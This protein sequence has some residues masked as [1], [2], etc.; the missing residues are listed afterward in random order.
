M[1]TVV[2]S[3]GII[4][5]DSQTSAGERI[6]SLKTDKKQSFE[7]YHFFSAGR[8]VDI[9][10]L[11]AAVLSGAVEVPN[12]KDGTLQA[13]A[14]LV[15]PERD[16]YLCGYVDEELVLQPIEPGDIEAIGSGADYAIGAM[17]AGCDA[18][19]AVKIAAG[20]D[21]YTGGRIRKFIV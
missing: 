16:V 4:A 14:L 13:V 21:V 18:V 10:K 15:T 8:K 17:D 6:V 20:R 3:N 19:Q 2:Y 1:T 11:I 12:T 5:Y 7:G 9:D